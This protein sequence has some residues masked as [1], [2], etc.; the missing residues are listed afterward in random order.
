MAERFRRRE[1]ATRYQ[2]NEAVSNDLGL[3]LKNGNQGRIE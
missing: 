3:S 1:M 2:C